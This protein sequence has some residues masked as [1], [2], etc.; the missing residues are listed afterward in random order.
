MSLAQ[1][2]A[3]VGRHAGN[4]V[5]EAGGDAAGGQPGASVVQQGGPQ[6]RG[7]DDAIRIVEGVGVRLVALDQRLE[8]DGRLR[9]VS[10]GLPDAGQRRRGVEQ[11]AHAGGG[12]TIQP[13]LDLA[14]QDGGQV[15]VGGAGVA[16]GR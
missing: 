6:R 15:G 1:G 12:R 10:H 9:F 5:V 4:A 7:V 11:P 13:R 14:A 8:L 2:A 3:Y 16:E